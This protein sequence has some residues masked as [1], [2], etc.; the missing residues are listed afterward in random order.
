MGVGLWRWGGSGCRGRSEFSDAV[1][2]AMVVP[3]S[4]N[5]VEFWHVV[6]YV[7]GTSRRFELLYCSNTSFFLSPSLFPLPRL[8]TISR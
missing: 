4:G 3:S 6:E 1:W 8:A 2:R 7:S 5:K